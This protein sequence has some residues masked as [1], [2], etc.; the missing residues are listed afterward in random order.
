MTFE[1]MERISG[2]QKKDL[3]EELK[4][5]RLVLQ[6]VLAGRN[7]ERLTMITGFESDKGKGAILLI[8]C[9][10]GFS[11]DVPDGVGAGVTIEFQGKDRVQ[12]AFKSRIVRVTESDLFLE[13]PESIARVQRRNHFR[14]AP[15]KGTRVSFIQFGQAIQGEPVNLSEG[16]V[17]LQPMQ[18]GGR[19]SVGE[20]IQ[21]LRLR[22]S[23]ENLSADILVEKA[24]VRREH[25][26]NETG[27]VS[28][29]MQFQ[30]MDA[31]DKRALH[32]FIFNC[33]REILMKRKRME[34]D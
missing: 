31:R 7:Y 29:A 26:D 6:L 23:L 28:Y 10:R 32:E 33:Q 9:P 21:N 27:K 14:I 18:R 13:L 20:T 17:L 2:K 12:Y 15:P 25:P 19:L 5:D 11:E 4:K 34:E 8:D 22:C 30:Q 24:V 16:G 3:L 1:T